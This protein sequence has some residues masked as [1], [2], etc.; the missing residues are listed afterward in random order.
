MTLE[1]SSKRTEKLKKLLLSSPY[2]IC[3]ERAKFFTEAYKNNENEPEIIKKAKAVEYTLKN[4][5]IF[6][7]EDELLV[8]NETSKNLGEKIC[9]ELYSYRDFTKK[10][11][12]KRLR[13]RKLQPFQIDD[14]DIEELDKF[15]PFWKHK[16]L[17]DNIIFKRMAEENFIARATRQQAYTPNIAIMTGTNEGHLC[18]GYE[19]ILKLGYKGI[20]NEAESYQT[21]LNKDDPEYEEK[22]NF[23]EAIKICYQA[24]IE[25]SKRYSQLADEMSRE[26]KDEIRKNELK[27]IGKITKKVP[28]NPPETFYEAIQAIW[29]TQNIAN[30]I[31]YR[32][33]LALGRLDQILYS[34]YENDLKETEYQE[35]PL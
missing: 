6:I 17:Y 30:I 3:I 19:K 7:R 31:Y 34:Y 24:G 5:T 10:R 16:A 21:N 1:V 11:N 13:N 33:V 29:F 14:S 12:L 27:K 8:G 4:L 32:S 18:F 9:F 25:F 22:F 20:I 23:Y 35:N 26:E 28:E 2:E 15:I